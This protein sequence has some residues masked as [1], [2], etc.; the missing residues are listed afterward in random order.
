MLLEERSCELCC[1]ILGKEE[2][3]GR[4]AAMMMNLMCA[5]A[6]EEMLE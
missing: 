1:F 6:L 3:E 2:G 5:Y 4:D